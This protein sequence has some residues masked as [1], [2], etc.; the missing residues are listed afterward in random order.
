VPVQLELRARRAVVVLPVFASPVFIVDA[1]ARRNCRQ[2]VSV[3]RTGAGGIRNRW[4]T[5]RIVEAPTRWP[6]L[7]NSP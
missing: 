2:V 6:S 5:R 7:S 4:R 3:S 1:C